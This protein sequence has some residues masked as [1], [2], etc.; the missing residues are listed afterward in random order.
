MRVKE[1][2][3]E[4]KLSLVFVKGTKRKAKQCRT[5]EKFQE[6]SGVMEC[7]QEIWESI[8]VLDLY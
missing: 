1:R 7:G 2:S 6:K 4:K 5:K 8:P 3:K